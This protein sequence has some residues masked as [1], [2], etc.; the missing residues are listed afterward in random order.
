VLSDI[1]FCRF[2]QFRDRPGQTLLVA[3][4]LKPFYSLFDAG[5]EP[6]APGECRG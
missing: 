4:Q 5:A 6:F 3:D 1:D 2:F